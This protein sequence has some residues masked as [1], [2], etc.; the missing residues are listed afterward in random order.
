MI[1]LQV[2]P[3]VLVF[4]LLWFVF[5]GLPFYWIFGTLF[6]SF[7]G[8]YPPG[9]F[10]IYGPHFWGMLCFCFFMLFGGFYLPFQKVVMYVLY[11]ELKDVKAARGNQSR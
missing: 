5:A 11:R 6:F 2:L 9:M 8:H 1:S 7:A 3:V 4:M 10:G